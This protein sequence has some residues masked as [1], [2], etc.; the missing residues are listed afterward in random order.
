MSLP[1]A[2]ARQNYLNIE[3]FRR[4]GVGVQ[5]PVWFAQDGNLLYVVTQASTGKVKRIRRSGR[6]N[7][8]P[9][10]MNG[11]LVGSWVPAQAREN[12]DPDVKAKVDRLLDRK[13]GLMRKLFGLGRSGRR[14]ADTVLEIELVEEI[15]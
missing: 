1:D 11:R 7:V 2:F 13:Y 3:T 4:N 12:A 10:R 15:H 5:T 9:C 8:A 6:V 14:G